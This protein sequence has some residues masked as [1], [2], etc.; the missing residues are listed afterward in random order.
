MTAMLLPA[1]TVLCIL[2]GMHRRVGVYDAFVRGA[3][4]G[5]LTLLGMMP[6]L[7]A[8]LTATALLRAS[9]AMDAIAYRAS[10]VLS[11]L[12]LPQEAAGVILLRP[13]SGSAAMGAA[14][15][16][17]KTFGA[18]S[19]AGRFV[20]VACAAGET[21]FFTGSLYLGAAKVTRSRYALPVALIAYAVG[22]LTAGMLCR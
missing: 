20:C 8:I 2:L 5:L 10:P 12:D 17:M 14:A 18:D 7:A 22:V 3:K 1:L 11:F 13:F 9:G 16:V 6:Y 15:D 19:R 4:D 21:V